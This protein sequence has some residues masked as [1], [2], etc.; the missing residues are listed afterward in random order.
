MA[1]VNG[2]TEH[3]WEYGWP[4]GVQF[5]YWPLNIADTLEGWAAIFIAQGYETTD[6]YEIEPGFEK[7]AVYVDLADMAPSHVAISDGRAWKSKLGGDYDIEHASLELLEGEVEDE[8]GIVAQVLK[9][10]IMQ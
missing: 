7:V 3:V 6:S 2:D 8:Y 1:Y 5:F 4:P 9:K 10:E